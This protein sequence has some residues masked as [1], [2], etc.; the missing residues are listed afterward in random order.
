M[1]PSMFHHFNHETLLTIIANHSAP[2]LHSRAAVFFVEKPS[3]SQA[4]ES[5]LA[6]VS[7]KQFGSSALL[8]KLFLRSRLKTPPIPD[9]T[10][11]ENAQ[12]KARQSGAPLEDDEE[13]QRAHPQALR[14]H[15]FQHR[16]LPLHLRLRRRQHAQHPPERRADRTV[17]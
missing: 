14:Q 13:G 11:V 12:I 10:A 4:V 1:K 17:R 15:P 16:H 2:L 7:A 5:S 3:I 8:N 9:Q 6:P